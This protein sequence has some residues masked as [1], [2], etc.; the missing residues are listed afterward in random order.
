MSLG[1]CLIFDSMRMNT[2]ITKN[3]ICRTKKQFQKPLAI[4]LDFKKQLPCKI[5]LYIRDK[6]KT[7][8]DELIQDGIIR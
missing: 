4:D 5:P 7:L 1:Y 6:L 8:L 2:P 3:D